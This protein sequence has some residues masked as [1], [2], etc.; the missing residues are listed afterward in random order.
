[1]P[2]ANRQAVDRLDDATLRNPGA[3]APPLGA[4]AVRQDAHFRVEREIP[5]DNRSGGR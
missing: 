1:M 3:T 2:G 5:R 4:T